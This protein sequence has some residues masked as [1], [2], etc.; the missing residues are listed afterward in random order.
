MRES[1]RNTFAGCHLDDEVTTGQRTTTHKNQ[2]IQPRQY[3]DHLPC[4]F[5]AVLHH[6][7]ISSAQVCPSEKNIPLHQDSS[8]HISAFQRPVQQLCRHLPAH[9]LVHSDNSRKNRC[10]ASEEPQSIHFF[11]NTSPSIFREQ[12]TI[13]Y[14]VLLLI[15]LHHLSDFME[16]FCTILRHTVCRDAHLLFSV[17]KTTYRGSSC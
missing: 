1:T 2:P 12:R 17:I 7:V 11:H 14:V 9:T 13:I 3:S 8:N 6:Q 4:P 5:E 10:P 15:G 16:N